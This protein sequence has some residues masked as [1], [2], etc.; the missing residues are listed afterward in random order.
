MVGFP[1]WAPLV[2]GVLG[3]AELLGIGWSVARVVRR[4][5]HAPVP[6]WAFA[7]L[8]LVGYTLQEFL[9]R[10][11]V[12]SSFPW[13]FVLQPTY[14]V[15]LLLQ[16]PFAL[17]VYLAARLLLRTVERIGKAIS[18][19]P[20]RFAVVVACVVR[21]AIEPDLLRSPE[22]STLCFGRGPPCDFGTA[23]A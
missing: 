11:L 23:P 13:W 21:R 16:L 14:R 5:P 12:G 19:P 4:R 22:L 9:E 2:L 18:V 17:V 3:G 6:P 1:G 10:W 7:L 20:P 8:P 15:G